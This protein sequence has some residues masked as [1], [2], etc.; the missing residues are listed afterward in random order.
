MLRYKTITEGI[1]AV[2]FFGSRKGTHNITGIAVK[3]LYMYIVS[4]ISGVKFAGDLTIIFNLFVSSI[5]R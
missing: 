3:K 5:V 4:L 1:F 2:Y